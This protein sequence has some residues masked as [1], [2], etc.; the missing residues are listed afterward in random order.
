MR[1]PR[2]RLTVRRMMGAVAIA[3]LLCY[4][5][6][7]WERHTDRGR[8]AVLHSSL[9]RYHR[10]LAEVNLAQAT[11][12]QRSADRYRSTRE[13][14]TPAIESRESRAVGNIADQLITES[15]SMSAGHR[16]DAEGHSRLT[17]YHDVLSRKYEWAARRPWL[18]ATPDPPMPNGPAPHPSLV[19]AI[20]SLQRRQARLSWMAFA[21]TGLIVIHFCCIAVQRWRRSCRTSSVSLAGSVPVDSPLP[22]EA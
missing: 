8:L 7:L 21:V 5:A 13:T 10:E 22:P 16:T 3:G 2:L 20:D 9:S 15:E 19:P 4:A 17:E 18:L 14:R 11:R 1:L 12:Q 6:I